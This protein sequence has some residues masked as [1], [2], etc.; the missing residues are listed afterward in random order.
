MKNE[1]VLEKI[2]AKKEIWKVIVRRKVSMIGH[3][4]RH[5]KMEIVIVEETVEAKNEL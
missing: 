3:N 5:S 2:G 1:K 4:L